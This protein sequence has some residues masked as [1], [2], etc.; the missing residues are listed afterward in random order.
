MPPFPAASVV[1]R[2]DG[3]LVTTGTVIPVTETAAEGAGTLT[4]TMRT[5]SLAVRLKDTIPWLV[6]RKCGDAIVLE[7]FPDRLVAHLVELKSTV[8]DR[9][10][11]DAV[12]QFRGAYHNALAIAG[13]LELTKPDEIRCHVAFKVDRV[14]PVGNASPSGLKTRLGRKPAA[15]A[16]DWIARRLTIDELQDIPFTWTHRGPDGNAAVEIA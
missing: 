12:S 16:V 2:I 10:F 7:F 6:E 1:N 8:G 14:S 5:H 13:V 15:N 11:E 9:K 3:N 4:L